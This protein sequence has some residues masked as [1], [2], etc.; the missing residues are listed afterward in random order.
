MDIARK[1]QND[2]RF[3]KLLSGEVPVSA[4]V[5]DPQLCRAVES[6]AKETDIGDAESVARNLMNGPDGDKIRTILDALK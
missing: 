6:L 1:L 2:P 3:S 5:S 4:L